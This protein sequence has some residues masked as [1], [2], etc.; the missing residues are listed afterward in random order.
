[1][2]REIEIDKHAA[3]EPTAPI[4][5]AE[6]GIARLSLLVGA[7]ALRVNRRIVVSRYSKFIAASGSTR[8]RIAT[9]LQAVCS[10]LLGAS[11]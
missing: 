8:C 6:A 5:Q 9:A 3:A 2:M 7:S 11:R 4:A 1:M 10:D